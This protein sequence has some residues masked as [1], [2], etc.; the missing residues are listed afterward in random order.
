[1]EEKARQLSRV[2]GETFPAENKEEGE[3]SSSSD[4][5]VNFKTLIHLVSLYIHNR[6]ICMSVCVCFYLCMCVLYMYPS[7]L[8]VFFTTSSD[9]RLICCDDLIFLYV[10]LF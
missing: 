8:Y 6:Y 9:Y 10:E 1:M 4:D 3:L 2:S 7:V 5:D